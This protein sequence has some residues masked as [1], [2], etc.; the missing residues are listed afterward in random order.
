MKKFWLLFVLSITFLSL[1]AQEKEDIQSVNFYGV[2]FSKT[3]AVGASETVLQFV[4]A[5]QGINELFLSEPAKYD[6]S[7]A[8]KIKVNRI[9]VSQASDRAQEF[10]NNNLVYSDSELMTREDLAYIVSQYETKGDGYGLLY[11]ADVLDKG[12][13]TGYFHFVIF[14]EATGEIIKVSSAT[15]KAKGFGLRNFW[16]RSVLNAM[17]TVR[18]Q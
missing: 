16:A 3:N 14:S 10:D 9:D 5:F 6:A 8:M 1:Q 17:K 13:S 12:H 7:K 11:I 2:D 4:Q 15:G 18:F